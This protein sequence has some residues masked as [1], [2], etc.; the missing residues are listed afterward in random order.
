VEGGKVASS[1]L[2]TTSIVKLSSSI[3]KRKMLFDVLVAIKVCCN[4]LMV[5]IRKSITDCS[6]D[7]NL[8]GLHFAGSQFST[9]DI[10]PQI[11]H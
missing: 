3:M 8:Q 1:L 10:H 5:V 6:C 11:Y 9:V 2:A 4:K 7:T